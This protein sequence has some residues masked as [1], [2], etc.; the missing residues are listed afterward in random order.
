MKNLS[1]ALQSA[2]EN[3]PPTKK[4]QEILNRLYK[5]LDSYKKQS[6]AYYE[7]LGE[8]MKPQYFAKDEVLYEQGQVIKKAYFLSSG[9]MMAN[10]YT[11]KEGDKHVVNIFSRD[12]IISGKSFTEQTPS[13]YELV[14]CKGT[15]VLHLT[16]E[17]VNTIY[18]KFPDT[19]EQAMI[20]LADKE[21]KELETKRML[22]LERMDMV[23]EFYKRHPELL[24]AGKIIKDSDI[25]SF[26]LIGQSTLRG[27]RAKLKH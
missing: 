7:Y 14:A 1:K 10:H 24:K 6:P 12:E 11:E 19:Q 3:E 4:H 27:L 21:K 25:A 5:T 17:E 15:Y 22:G 23:A 18:S 16:Y 2:N 13:D 20:I 9:F 26:L 8:I